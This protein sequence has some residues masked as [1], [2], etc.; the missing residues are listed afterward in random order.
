MLW[1]WLTVTVPNAWLETPCQ[2]PIPAPLTT[3]WAAIFPHESSARSVTLLCDCPIFNTTMSPT[4]S[5][6]LGKASTPPP[7]ICC[8]VATK[9]GDKPQSGSALS[10]LPLFSMSG[11]KVFQKKHA[12]CIWIKR[13]RKEGSEAG[14][15]GWN[16]R[17]RAVTAPFHLWPARN[18]SLCSNNTQL[19]CNVD[20]LKSSTSV[21]SP[22]WCAEG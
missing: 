4:C 16:K 3:F 2:S 6:Q 21:L 20:R 13:N 5:K 1:T 8:Q 19:H 7:R 14:F 12:S 18:I 17:P 15:P 10:N 9:S 22:C 11:S